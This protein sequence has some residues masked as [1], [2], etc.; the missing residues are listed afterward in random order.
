MTSSFLYSDRYGRNRLVLRSEFLRSKKQ[1]SQDGRLDIGTFSHFWLSFAHLQT[2]PF[3]T[4][5]RVTGTFERTCGD[6]KLCPPSHVFL[7]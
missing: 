7:K 3:L 6:S 5:R 1:H 2:T 4:S